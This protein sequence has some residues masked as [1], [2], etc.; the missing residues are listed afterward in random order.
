[1]IYLKFCGTQSSEVPIDQRVICTRSYS[2]AR[3]DIGV[4]VFDD[5]G[6]WERVSERDWL[7]CFVMSETGKTIDK[8]E[9]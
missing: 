8:I 5:Q 1:M 4:R 3:D 6:N 9:A 2:A 7:N